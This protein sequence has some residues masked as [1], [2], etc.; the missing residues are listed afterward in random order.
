MVTAVEP[1]TTLVLTVKLAEVL[2]ALTVTVAG[3]VA[4]PVLLLDKLTTASLV[5]AALSVTVPVEVFPP[6][7]VLGFIVTDIGAMGLTLR[8]AVRV[9]L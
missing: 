9:A 4:T 7:T 8:F 1:V 5:G 3:T 6:T 2:P